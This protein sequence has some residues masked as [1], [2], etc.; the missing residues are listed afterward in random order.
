MNKNKLHIILYI[1]LFF[2][3]LSIPTTKHFLTKTQIQ[4]C[5]NRILINRPKIEFNDSI[6]NNYGDYYE[7]NFGFRDEINKLNSLLKLHLFASSSKPDLTQL[8]KNNWLF[9]TSKSDF[10]F[11]SYSNTNL[12]TIK[13]LEEITKTHEDRRRK[14]EK[15][16]CS[17]IIAI[18]PNKST[19]YPEFVPIN[20]KWSKKGNQSKVDQVIQ[21][22][23]QKKSKI[24][25]VYPKD[26]LLNCKKNQLYLK[27]DSHWN[28]LGA[29]ISYTYFLNKTKAILKIKPTKINDFT[30]QYKKEN[31]GDLLSLIGICNEPFRSDYIPTFKLKIKRKIYYRINDESYKHYNPSAESKKTIIFFRDSYTKYLIPFISNHFKT[32]YYYWTDYNQK[33][34]DSIKP[35]IVVVSKVE[36]YF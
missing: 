32:S 30:I 20:L 13:Q 21:Y 23:N 5:E 31:K 10:S 17:Y 6:I 36:R 33:I 29:F 25:F 7:E 3:V 18:W 9:P 8:G 24:V 19:I 16:K 14:L 26:T 12:L 4:N 35:D 1:T 34:V 27:H 2:S 28:E 11:E 15:K 22:F